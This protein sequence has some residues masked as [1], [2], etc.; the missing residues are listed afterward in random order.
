MNMS[1]KYEEDLTDFYIRGKTVVQ[2]ILSRI[3]NMF[4]FRRKAYLASMFF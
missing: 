3:A 1:F 2:N 4:Q